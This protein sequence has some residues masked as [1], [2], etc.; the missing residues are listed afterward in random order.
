MIVAQGYFK[1]EYIGNIAYEI[2][3]RLTDGEIELRFKWISKVERFAKRKESFQYEVSIKNMIVK[4]T[5]KRSIK[6]FQKYIEVFFEENIGRTNS[7][8]EKLFECN[9]QDNKVI[10]YDFHREKVNKL[11]NQ[12]NMDEEKLVEIL[13]DKSVSGYR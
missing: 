9:F 8:E 11:I 6:E 10:C 5:V 12:F 2:D 7:I 13:L 4:P 3:E 1:R